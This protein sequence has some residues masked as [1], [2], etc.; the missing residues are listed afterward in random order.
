MRAGWIEIPR[1]VA[2]RHPLRPIGGWLIL[3]GF[4]LVMPLLG[5][6]VFLV[7][8]W[9]EPARHPGVPAWG[10]A[11]WNAA[12]VLGASLRVGLLVL[13]VRRFPGFRP[14]YPP[15]VLLATAADTLPTL[16]L[17]LAAGPPDAAPWRE[18]SVEAVALAFAFVAVDLVFAAA[19]WRGRRFRL[20]FERRVPPDD[21]ILSTAGPATDAR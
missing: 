17:T 21:P 19:A 2:D 8:D 15:L 11:A 18:H 13:Y 12:L 6:P 20:V 9:N 10:P 4:W 7:T 5:V 1:E 3:F 14:L 16:L